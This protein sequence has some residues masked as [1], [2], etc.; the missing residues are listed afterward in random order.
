M[1]IELNIENKAVEADIKKEIALMLYDKEIFSL[2]KAAA[3]AE[4]SKTEF[5]QFM[6]ERNVFIKYSI[7]DIKH[8]LDNIQSAL[9]DSGK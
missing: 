6:K 5:M 7:D 1:S 2:G 3:F 8:D 4:L 9:N